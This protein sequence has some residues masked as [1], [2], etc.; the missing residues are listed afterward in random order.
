LAR[1][2]HRTL[3]G[4]RYSPEHIAWCGDIRRIPFKKTTQAVVP[5]LEKPEMDALLNAPDHLCLQ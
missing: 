1:P 3:D 4:D 5:Y 2:Y